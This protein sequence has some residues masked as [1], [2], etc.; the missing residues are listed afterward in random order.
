MI[1][2]NFE[3]FV[4]AQIPIFIA[5]EILEKMFVLKNDSASDLP[6]IHSVKLQ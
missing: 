5:Q 1:L 2:L 6:A 4:T 3:G